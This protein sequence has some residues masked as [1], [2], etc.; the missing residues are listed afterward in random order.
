MYNRMSEP[1]YD[2]NKSGLLQPGQ[3]QG[4]PP[5]SQP[6]MGPAPPMQQQPMYPPPMQQPMPQQPTH[7]HSSNSN[8]TV[9]I[10][11]QPQQLIIQGPRAWST[12]ICSCFDDCGVCKCVNFSLL[13]QPSTR[14]NRTI[15]MK[16]N[17][18]YHI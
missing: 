1:G 13:I 14:N 8:T 2:E 5:Y 17:K 12:D 4:P 18:S 6:G 10:Q 3:E 16:E 7:M 15:Y 9:V 11:Q